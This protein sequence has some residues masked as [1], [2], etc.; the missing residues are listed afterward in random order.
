MTRIAIVGLSAAVGAALLLFATLGRPWPA[1][2]QQPAAQTPLPSGYVGA[3]TCKGCHE[4]AFK[5]FETTRMG[6]LFLK[7]PRNTKESL[8]CENCH[9]PG[10][11]HVEAG[12]G[13]GA[14]GMIT[15]AKNDK[16]PVETRNAMC[17]T[18][19]TK[20]PHL[21]WKGSS[22]GA[23]RRVHQLPQGDGGRLPA[24]P[25]R[26][27]DGDRNLRDVPPSEAGAADALLAHAAARGENDV[28]VVP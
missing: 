16:T 4:E 7:Q 21:F 10:Q 26:P 5:K 9:G 24:Q 1:P 18:C 23:R 6:R 12:G 8:A 2:A 28:H 14:G 25:A 3:E 27:G 20:G 11:K 19:H 17:I 13:K 15:F 22:R